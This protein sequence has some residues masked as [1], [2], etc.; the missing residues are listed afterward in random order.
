MP[1][2]MTGRTLVLATGHDLSLALFDDGLLV[3]RHHEAIERGHAE[4]LMPALAALLGNEQAPPT[5]CDRVIFEVGPGSFTGLRVGAAAAR[6]LALVWD[7]ALHG[8]RSTL[9][10]AAHVRSLGETAALAVGLKAPRGQ[11]WLE[12]FA[13]GGLESLGPPEALQAGRLPPLGGYECA[14]DGFPGSTHGRLRPDAASVA[15]LD[16]RAFSAPD[17][18]YVRE[19][20]LDAAA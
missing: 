4:R 20:G 19:A 8:V 14:G 9:L 2:R 11:L 16:P 6:A 15:F 13:P 12:R 10:V 18:L 7:A 17:L 5:R 1:D 3:S